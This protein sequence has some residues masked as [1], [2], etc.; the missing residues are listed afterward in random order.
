VKNIT[1]PHLFQILNILF[2]E[3]WRIKQSASPKMA[4][5]MTFFRLMQ[6]KPAFSFDELIEKLDRIKTGEVTT[7]NSSTP[8]AGLRNFKHAG[9]NKYPLDQ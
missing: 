6:V 3:E 5:E 1:Q 2:E 9:R 4:L 8:A 7:G